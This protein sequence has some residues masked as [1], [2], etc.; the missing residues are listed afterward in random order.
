MW[1]RAVGEEVG[2]ASVMALRLGHMSVSIEKEDADVTLS[3]P[4]IHTVGR[5]VI[6]RAGLRGFVRY[7]KIQSN[8]EH[9][10]CRAFRNK[11][12]AQCSLS[13]SRISNCGW[14]VKVRRDVTLL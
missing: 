13:V 7:R 6:S 1:G 11:T 4:P 8:R 10:G 9:I 12:P 14:K 2:G 5:T 3:V